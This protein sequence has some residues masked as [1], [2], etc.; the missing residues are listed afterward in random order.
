M[1]PKR[2]LVA[3]LLASLGWACGSGGVAVTLDEY[4]VRVEPETKAGL[5]EFKVRNVGQ[6]E[7]ELD[8]LRTDLDPDGLPV[9]DAE[10]R[11]RSAGITLVTKTGRIRAGDSA[12][13]SLLLRPGRYVLI[14]NVPG[15][16]QSGMRTALR[17]S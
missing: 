1:G 5:V 6:I 7:H 9:K 11:V 8:V 17:V 12:E 14:C 16:Y 3:T 10:V 15:H 2:M 13:L 4:S